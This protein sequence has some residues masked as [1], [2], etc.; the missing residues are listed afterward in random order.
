MNKWDHLFIAVFNTVLIF[1]ITFTIL[2][3]NTDSYIRI[4]NKL[5]QIKGS[6]ICEDGEVDAVGYR[7]TGDYI[8]NSETLR[9]F[10]KGRNET[11]M[12]KTF[13]HEYGHHI[14]YTQLEEDFKSDWCNYN[15]T[16]YPSDYAETD[17][18][19]NYAETYAYIRMGWEVPK[20]QLEMI[21][22]ET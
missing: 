15:F 21:K 14:W 22:N 12:E 17:C 3:I 10:S 20:Q 1:G 19:E 13:W 2:S 7:T 8:P 18:K 5:E 16:K 11:S 4:N 6:L 9:I